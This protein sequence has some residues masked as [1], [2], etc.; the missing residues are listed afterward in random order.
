[1]NPAVVEHIDTL[2]AA[3]QA[4]P[5]YTLL[6]LVLFPV[7]GM[8]KSM[9]SDIKGEH[10]FKNSLNNRIKFV[11]SQLDNEFLS[12][13]DRSRLAQQYIQLVNQRMYGI[14]NRHIQDEVIKIIDRSSEIRSNKYFV[15]HRHYLSVNV[16]GELFINP[17]K[18]RERYIEAFCLVGVGVAIIFFAIFVGIRAEVPGLL[19]LV[20][21][22]ILYILGLG[23]FPVGK[24]GRRRAE[25]EIENYYQQQKARIERASVIE[26]NQP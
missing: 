2:L 24:L 23:H 12:N 19:F 16:E 21:G 25:K 15:M 22:M 4:H 14:E 8:L 11:A 1:M 18:I 10:I 17:K 26:A 20:V 7:L 9:F 13:E 6:L 3:I 5:F